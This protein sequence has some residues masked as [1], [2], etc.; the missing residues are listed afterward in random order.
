MR[1]VI[2]FIDIFIT[3][4]TQINEELNLIKYLFDYKKGKVISEQKINLISE[5][6][7]LQKN[8]I[9]CG[10]TVY[11][12]ES[13]ITAADVDGYTKS[14]FECPKG[15]GKLPEKKETPVVKTPEQIKAD[16]ETNAKK[17][18]WGTDVK[19]YEASG[20]KCDSKMDV[21]SIV[22][23]TAVNIQNKLVS[24]G[25]DIGPKGVDGKLGAKSMLAIWEVLK[26]VK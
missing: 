13:A 6:T 1:M 20:W 5:Q 2:G 9:S 19:A 25:K 26:T 3:M 16:L 18:G 8:A 22:K 17:C 11:S 4:K 7:E 23:D 14:G 21:A 12:S 15:S 10:W 24:L